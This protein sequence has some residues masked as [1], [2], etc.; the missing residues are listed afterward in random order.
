MII[1]LLSGS[2]DSAHEEHAHITREA[3]KR[4]GLDGVWWLVS[5]GNPLKARGP[6]PMNERIARARMAMHHPG[7]IMIDIEARLGTR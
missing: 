6:A 5:S 2:F 4:F 1:G 3:M 7:V